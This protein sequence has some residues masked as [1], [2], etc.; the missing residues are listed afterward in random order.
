MLPEYFGA[1]PAI[2]GN[3]AL[4]LWDSCEKKIPNRF[5]KLFL[6]LYISALSRL[7]AHVFTFTLDIVLFTS[8]SAPVISIILGDLVLVVLI[9]FVALPGIA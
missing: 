6:R 5:D 7:Y 8:F 9:A 4:C 2:F 1:R 3:H